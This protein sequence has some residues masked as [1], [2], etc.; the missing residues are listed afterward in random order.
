MAKFITIIFILLFAVFRVNAQNEYNIWYFGDHA[1]LNFNTQPPSPLTNSNLK[2]WES[3]SSICDKNG[4]LLFYT[5]GDSIYNKNH[6]LLK[7]WEPTL[8]YATRMSAILGSMIVPVPGSQKLYYIIMGHAIEN[9][10]KDTMLRYWTIDMNGDGGLGEVIEKEKPLLRRPNE[11][12]ALTLHANKKDFWVVNISPF[13][14]QLNAI[15]TVNGQFSAPPLSQ[16][17]V[18]KNVSNQRTSL[19]F[20]PDSKLLCGNESSTS[21][22]VDGNLN[23]YPFNNN[24]GIIGV[25]VQISIPNNFPIITFEFSK[26]SKFIYIS[27]IKRSNSID[28][29]F[30]CQYDLTNFNQ[31]SINSS[32]TILYSKQIN[33]SLPNNCDWISQL[34]LGPDGKIYCFNSAC[35]NLTSIQFPNQKGLACNFQSKIINLSQKTTISGGPYYPNFWF[36]EDSFKLG[37]DTTLCIG[38]SL[39]L[40]SKLITYGRSFKWNTGDSTPAI[41]VKKDGQYILTVTYP[42]GKTVSDTII[43]SYK[44]KFKLYL[45]NDTAF[46]RQFSHQLN[47]GAGFKKYTWSNNDSS[48]LITVNQKGIYSVKVIDSNTC[49]QGD[50]IAIDEI[51]RPTITLIKDTLT[52]KFVFLSVSRQNG[53]SYQWSNGDTGIATTVINKGKYT[54]TASH[55]FC[56]N[57]DTV[58]VTELPKP[59]VYLGP[60]TTICEPLILKTNE[61]GKYLWN[62]GA[63]TNFIT[64]VNPG[65][66]SISVTRNNCTTADTIELIPCE[67]LT[68]F[69]PDAFSPNGDNINDVFT[70]SGQRIRFVELTIY[71]RWGEQLAT[72]AGTTAAWDGTY[73]GSTC[74][75]D[76]YFYRIKLLGYMNGRIVYRYLKGSLT[77]LR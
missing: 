71:N 45:G 7:N 60:D 8:P 62:T 6:Q 47:A 41:T 29:N 51:K 9:N 40:D 37:N 32:K 27:Y 1:G 54:I 35:L 66:Y 20:S 69:I 52:C 56:N 24:S 43:V 3:A 59:V 68:Y 72:D 36:R 75:Q 57:S 39:L 31:A 48:M 38:D 12:F 74:Q 49:P 28:S 46:C 23:I 55:K 61:A 25:P 14:K 50:T 34:Q 18:I 16:N 63:K 70:V 19:K 13:F 17:V 4:N 22:F 77:L 65:R 58:D 5:N 2:S 64:A 33:W 44:P 73:K 76:V 67:N 30:V 10:G 21:V 11:A 53:V 42:L 26:N 15:R